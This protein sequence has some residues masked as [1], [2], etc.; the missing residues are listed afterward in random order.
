[1]QIMLPEMNCQ[2]PIHMVVNT[3]DADRLRI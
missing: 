3:L 1:M 2:M